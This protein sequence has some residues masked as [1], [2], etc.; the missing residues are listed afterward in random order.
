MN[1]KR[2]TSTVRL[3]G[4]AFWLLAWRNLRAHL[5]RTLLSALTVALGV[6]MLVATSVFR[7]GIE[8]AWTA[9]ANKFAFIT[10]ISNLTFGGVGLMMLGA[11]GFLI[12]NAFAMSVTQQQRQIGMLRSLG[13]MRAQ[14]LRL[15]LVE[16]LLTGGLGTALGVFGG[17]LVGNGIL[18]AMAYFGVETGR[19]SASPGSIALAVAMGLGISLL[20]ALVPARRAAG[21]SPLEALRDSELVGQRG[22]EKA[23]KRASDSAK[24]SHLTFHVSRLT[25]GLVLLISLWAYLAI[26][27]PGEWTGYHQPWDMILS[28]ILLFVWWIGLVLVTPAL[29]G[30]IVRGL[31]A[32]LRRSPG[33]WLRGGMGRLLGDNLGR[34]PERLHLTALTFAVGLLMMVSTGGFV[35]FCNDVMVGRIAAQA[36]REQ[37]WTIYPFNRVK[38]L[39]QLQGFQ[40]DAP[41]LE[42]A[43]VAEIE[44]LAAGRA[45][46]EPMYL[47]PVPEI[48]APFPGFPSMLTLD[49]EMLTRPGRFHMVE[50]DWETAIP[51]LREGCG[52][53]VSPAIA[54]RHGAGVGEPIAV[55]GR[56]GPVSCVVAATGAGGFAPMSFIGP[57]G[58]DLFVVPGRAPD[59]LQVRPLSSTTDADIAALSA[60]LYALAARYGDDRVFVARP[61]D[62]LKAIT[63]TSDQLTQIMNGLLLLAV[64]GGALGSVNTTLVSILERR[65]ELALLRALGAT[66][67]Q[68]A[69]L[70]V[71]ESAI[72]GLLGALLGLLAGWGTIAIY[73]LV[74]GGVTFGQVDLPLWTAVAEVSWP[75]LRGGMPGL[76]A[77]PLL[78]GLAAYMVVRRMD[79]TT[80]KREPLTRPPSRLPFYVS[81]ARRNL[82]G[83][84]LRTVLSIATVALGVA[85]IVATNVVGAGV[86]TGI[87]EAVESVAFVTDMVQVGLNIASGMILVAAGFLIYNA[88][89]MAVV[90]RRQQI[91]SLRALGMTR[92]QVLRLVLVEAL[93]VGGLGATLGLLA[94]PLLGTGILSA[95]RAADY[96]V[97]AGQVSLPGL[98]LGLLLGL[99]IAV[100]AALLP[101]RCAARVAPLE[102]L[103][104]ENTV[105]TAYS[106]DRNGALRITL[107][108]TLCI[109][110]LVYLVF[111]PPGRWTV[112]PWNYALPIALSAVWLGAGLLLAP[113]LIGVAGHALRQPLTRLARVAGSLVA[114]NLRRDR[115]RVTLTALTFAV[116]VLTIVS[117]TGIFNFFGRELITYAQETHR[118]AGLQHGWAIGAADFTLGVADP[119]G[120]IAP[121]KPEV[122]A[123]VRAVVGERGY[124]GTEHAL[125]IPELAAVLVPNYFSSM[126]D[127]DLLRVPGNVTLLE[128]EL[129]AALAVMEAGCGVLLA[130]G[131]AQRHS[132]GVGD[133]LTIQSDRGPLECEVAGVVAFGMVPVSVISPAVKGYFNVGEPTTVI[134]FPKAG[135]DRAALEADLLAIDE[136]YGDDAW[137]MRTDESI[138]TVTESA[139]RVLGLMGGLLVLAMVAAALGTLNT[140]AMSV[141]ER[142]RELTLFRTIGATRRQTMTLVV[143]EAALTALLGSVLGLLAGLGIS[144][145]FVLAHGGNNW[146]YPGIDLRTATLRSWKPALHSGLWGL[147][148][149]P[150][151]AAGT[152]WLVVR[153]ADLGTP[154]TYSAFRQNEPR[155]TQYAVSRVLGLRERFVLGAA[156][157]LLI[158]LFSLVAA[159]VGHQQQYMDDGARQLAMLMAQ[160]QAQALELGL[161]DGATT[162]D[163][164]ALGGQLDAA[165]LLQLQALLE[166][167]GDTGL[168]GYT[169][170]DRDNVVLLSLN[171]REIGTLV[172]PLTDA[173][174]AIAWSEREGERWGI[175]ATAPI[176]NSTGEVVGAVRM[177]FDLAW[178]REALRELRGTLWA[179]GGGVSLLAL[180]LAWLLATPLVRVTQ[181]LSVHAAGVARGEYVPFAR[182]GPRGRS[183]GR[184]RW[185]WLAART[186]LRARFTMALVVTIL[187][188]VGSLELFALPIQRRHVEKTLLDGSTATVEWLG[189]TMSEALGRDD[190]STAGELGADF[191]LDQLLS[192]AGTLDWGQLQALGEQSRPDALAYIALADEEGVVILSDQLAFVGEEVGLPATTEV[193]E[194]RW[195]NEPIWTI[196][197]SLTRGRGGER[198][199]ALQMG[200]RRAEVEGFL[201]E[202]RLFFR[203]AGLVALLAG[204]LLAQVIGG[205]VAGPVQ[206]LA[207]SARRIAAGDL[208]VHFA[209]GGQDEVAQLAAAYNTMVAG[210]R[211]REWLR[212]LF[213]RFVSQEVAEAIR[214]GQ[215]RL[216]GENRVVSVLFCDIRGFTTRSERHTPQEIVT[217]LNA[218]LPVVVEAAQHHQGTVNKF[219]GDSTLVIYGA[220]RPL[221]ESAYQAVLT[222]LELRANLAR[223]NTHLAAS[224]NDPIRIGVG[225]NTGVVLAGAVGPHERQ[226]YTVIGDTVNL[227]S[228][229][230]ALNKDYPEHDILISGATYEALGSHRA[231]FTF[232]DLGEV[233]IRGKSGAVQVWAVQGQ[234]G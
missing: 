20:S 215:V 205:T 186:S 123:E 111:F 28:A 131:A 187:L 179:V 26:A 112:E 50:G 12:Y 91:G 118:A 73:V 195:R 1:D 69:R 23:R 210:L 68:I 117:I 136:K 33:R 84:T 107:T 9:G 5:A 163:L 166:D 109:G 224:G 48:S 37:A 192:T 120:M 182:A 78:A 228:R 185:A 222:A 180:A 25:L 34:A 125:V 19:G 79:F 181:Q 63:G 47:V 177:A 116:S 207:A 174:Q 202:S 108:A 219:G 38:G 132:A 151:L 3:T 149:A 82:Q 56:S 57:G 229:I 40:A 27:P 203:L 119:G 7:S 96:E 176:R 81:L 196:R 204:V 171:P 141:V 76:V 92:R 94:G 134:V 193:A 213:G 197:T 127:L 80:V 201:D 150:L 158:L 138:Q 161:P 156:A 32:L 14:V 142:Q 160:S 65:R 59:S 72:T 62:E 113:A 45:T 230:E 18:G 130:P 145:I 54:A 105:R 159:V 206:A 170:A 52:M 148:A 90:Q 178:V 157:L 88:F 208:D 165:Q 75:A 147:I 4:F 44:R 11:A 41:A 43:I 39:G 6:A 10:E 86:R 126:L 35:S 133:H 217:L 194:E 124:I 152:A 16:A 154:G 58:F 51:L 153:R 46:V 167:V 70:I 212:D 115:Q 172:P 22:S 67:R 61:E 232:V 189:E 74:Y 234:A 104:G 137:L 85:T 188:L 114:D 162:L 42:P 31:R 2:Q 30:A 211:E 53:L 218:Y 155:H 183:A 21:L 8:A 198:L 173:T 66:R 200:M 87:A 95:M 89:G 231:E 49:P 24:H 55:T 29:L 227:A 223:L 17:P 103:R 199:G 225:I 146:G 129:E 36:L 190:G 169:V 233:G 139:D 191:S 93:V 164:G 144:A 106:V 209:V 110:M 128:G 220:P 97:G 100:G 175:H 101:A 13:M 122:V 143:G 15:V 71:G 98:L 99:G 168:A 121:L 221:Q 140:T 184:S 216:E 77:A 60:D 64:G 102:A 83:H 226:E 214:T 135:V